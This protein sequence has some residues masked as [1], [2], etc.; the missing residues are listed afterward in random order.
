MNTYELMIIYSPAHGEAEV[1]K[2]FEGVKERVSSLGGKVKSEDFWGL[3]DLAYM[4]NKNRQAYYIV[5]SLDLDSLKTASLND[6]LNKQEA[7]VIRNMLTL[8]NS[9]DPV[10]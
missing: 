5:A 1:K 3:K 4:M 9:G 2:H 10:S 6:Y 8:V 7:Y